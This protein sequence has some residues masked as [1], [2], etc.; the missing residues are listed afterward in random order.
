MS[1]LL[2]PSSPL[3]ARKPSAVF[4]AA[5]TP[6]RCP[7]SISFFPADT[8]SRRRIIGRTTGFPSISPLK[9]SSSP[10]ITDEWGEEEEASEAA[11]SEPDPPKEDVDDEW[12]ASAVGEG[13]GTASSASATVE[14]KEEE[15]VK[16]GLSELEELK[17]C[18]VDTVYGS[19]LGFRASGEVRAEVLELV[20]QLEAKNPT[21]KPVQSPELLDGNWV[22]V[23]TAFS[24]LLPL[25]AAG[26]LP[27]VKVEKITQSID[28]SSLTIVNSTTLSSPFASISFSASAAFEVRSSTRIQVQFKEGT[29]EPP[30]VKPKIELPES[31]NIFGQ[32]ISLTPVQ[33]SLSP[34]QD[35][36]ASLSRTISGQPPLK[37]P[38]PGERTSSW[39]LVTYLDNDLRISRGDGGLFVLVKEGSPLLC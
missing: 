37:V 10:K 19:E 18:L 33:Q 27:L 15:E 26:A 35:A 38:I 1:L 21:S 12:G 5:G 14:E 4:T 22:L 20:N 39:L 29:F 9:F 28:S 23:Y 32:N 8:C 16:G 3:L 7:R 30:E 11:V 34:L 31:L 36:V 25:L 6:D 17:R 24:E 2:T 13:N